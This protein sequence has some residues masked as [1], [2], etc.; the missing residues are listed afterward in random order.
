MRFQKN[1]PYI[2]QYKYDQQETV[3]KKLDTSMKRGAGR[4]QEWT[5]VNLDIKYS[6]KIPISEAKK[7]DL[8]YLMN[9]KIIPND[10]YQF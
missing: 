2:M 8:K 3:F 7:K 9:C 10:Y 4:K 5:S 1:E 6:K